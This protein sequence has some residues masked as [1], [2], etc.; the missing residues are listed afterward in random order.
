MAQTGQS[1]KSQRGTGGFFSPTLLGKKARIGMLFVIPATVIIILMMIVPIFRTILFSFSSVTLPSFDTSFNGLRNFDKI[2]S[3]EEFS[4]IIR[5]TVVWILGTVILR[6]SLGFTSAL[7]MDDQGKL[8]RGMR[9]IALLPWTI[10]SIV[11][12]NSW[13]WMLRTDFGLVNGLLDNIGL[14]F[15]KSP[16]LID[17]RT[18]LPTVLVAYAWAGFPF[19]M[20]MLLAGL[21][22]IPEELYESGAMDGANKLQQFLYITI[23]SLRSVI[24]MVIVLEAISAINAFDL[25]FVL[26]GGGPG[27]SS[28]ILG[29]LIYRLGFTRFDF[30]GASAAST[31]LII[32]AL[33]CFFCYAPTQFIKKRS[34]KTL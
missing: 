20:M 31:L 9:V 6:V 23:P 15:L 34:D 2:F 8:L 13:R 30:A 3:L 27:T 4:T 28:E 24:V 21:Q 19:V 17:A 18:A 5:N 22:T 26:T 32:A 29:L 12:A 16:W 25:L 11:A 7:I 33:F 1:G 14:G 10:P